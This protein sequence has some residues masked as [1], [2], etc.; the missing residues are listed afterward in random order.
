[1]TLLEAWVQYPVAAALGRTLL[2]S[3]WEAGVIAIALAFVLGVSRSAQVRYASA[4][5]ALVM[6]LVTS[7]V[8]FVV[9]M[10][11]PGVRNQFPAPV[12]FPALKD[13]AGDASFGASDRL[14][15]DELVPWITPLW[16]AGFFL[17]NLKHLAGWWSVQR[18]RRRA[19]CAASKIWQ[20]RLTVLCEQ[21]LVSRTVTLVESSVA[22]FPIVIGHLRPIILLPVGVV[23]GMPREQVE[24][25]LMHELAHIRRH[26][27]AM[28]II[29]AFVENVFFYHP[30][31]WWVSRIIRTEREHCCDDLVVASTQDPYGYAAALAALEE[32]RT[33][34][35]EFALAATGGNLVKRIRRLLGKHDTPNTSWLPLFA[36]AFLIATASLVLHAQPVLSPA[37]E[38]PPPAP[39]VVVPSPPQPVIART[40]R[41]APP[42]IQKPAGSL[43][44]WLDQ[45]VAYIISREE[46]QAFESLPPGEEREKFIE[47]FWLRRDPTPGTPQNE[48]KEEHY[49]RIAHTNEKFTTAST[50]GWKTDRGRFLIMYGKP[51][52]LESHPEGMNSPEHQLHSY[53]VELWFYASMGLFEFADVSVNGEYRVVQDSHVTGFPAVITVLGEVN[54]PGIF[55]LKFRPTL[56]RIIALAQG[57]RAGAGDSI[58]IVRDQSGQKTTY[59]VDKTRLMTGAISDL[60]LEP[61]DTIIVPSAR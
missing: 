20:S 46:R 57:F 50:A 11:E 54:L 37:I 13:A 30:A 14:G 48:F 33:R 16:A 21:L 51:D 29:Q 36:I 7:V 60:Q 26:D 53:P 34:S 27:Y 32:S 58:Q 25:I 8:T 49:K 10:P 40:P 52:Q 35:E 61:N 43:T 1:M 24:L 3:L 6:M 59:Q 18:L 4:C 39:I 9:V 12:H 22:A 28:N 42:A 41:P 17:F 38:L 47:Q 56:I 45:D 19:T 23:T 31:V 15:F 44:P 2:H 55:K 5:I